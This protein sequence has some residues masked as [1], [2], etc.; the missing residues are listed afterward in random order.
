MARIWDGSRLVV[1]AVAAARDGAIAAGG[2]GAVAV[3][4]AGTVEV[5][6]G[7]GGKDGGRVAPSMRRE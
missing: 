4:V 7:S 5:E 1:V 6:V 2:A 3:A